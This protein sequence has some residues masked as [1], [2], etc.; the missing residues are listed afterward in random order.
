MR[1]RLSVFVPLRPNGRNSQFTQLMNKNKLNYEAPEVE[2]M[3]IIPETAV[4]TA[5]GSNEQP[6]YEYWF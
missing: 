5:S 4:L 2:I 6:D 3:E 1:H